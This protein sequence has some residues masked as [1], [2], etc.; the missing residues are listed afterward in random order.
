MPHGL[1]FVV[2]PRACHRFSLSPPLHHLPSCAE[3]CGELSHPSLL[4]DHHACYYWLYH[5]PVNGFNIHST[6]SWFVR[7]VAACPHVCSISRC[8]TAV[9]IFLLSNHNSLGSPSKLCIVRSGFVCILVQWFFFCLFHHIIPSCFITGFQGCLVLVAF[10]VFAG[11][12]H[13]CLSDA[14]LY[15]MNNIELSAHLMRV[16]SAC[17]M[18][19]LVRSH[20]NAICFVM[21]SAVKAISTLQACIGPSVGSRIHLVSG[22]RCLTAVL[23]CCAIF[24]SIATMIP[25]PLQFWSITWK[26]EHSSWSGCTSCIRTFCKD[27]RVSSPSICSVNWW[28]MSFT[29]VFVVKKISLQN[30][31]CFCSSWSNPSRFSLFRSDA[32]GAS[33]SHCPRGN[34][35]VDSFIW[36]S[37]YICSSCSPVVAISL[38]ATIKCTA[39]AFVPV[40]CPEWICLKWAAIG[41][42]IAVVM[43]W[44]KLL[45]FDCL[46]IYNS[47]QI[48][49]ALLSCIGVN[50]I[51]TCAS[52]SHVFSCCKISISG[53][54]CP[55][56]TW[57]KVYPSFSSGFCPRQYCLI[58]AGSSGS[59]LGPCRGRYDCV[60]AFLSVE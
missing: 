29:S 14:G 36:V 32:S 46:V 50:V 20:C 31:T 21:V 30:I 47:Q 33:S 15:C 27:H 19:L 58:P 57:I 35:V 45:Q 55:M 11:P 13:F 12:F 10:Y 40:F 52:V 59:L 60:R 49:C 5:Q 28:S 25:F 39:E 42:P 22:K 48:S 17:S 23:L 3:P 37:L 18:Q 53:F 7:P 16:L 4:F 34:V 54:V 41:R 24:G 26:N 43:A 1:C 9:L 2:T 56:N 6:E 38:S 44:A 8:F 51:W